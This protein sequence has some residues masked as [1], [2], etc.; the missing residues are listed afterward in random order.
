M[1][2]FW[3]EMPALRILLPFVAG[4]L[5]AIFTKDF[6]VVPNMPFIII[7][8][9]LVIIATHWLKNYRFRWLFG[10]TTAIILFC[11]GYQLSLQRT[12]NL[13]PQHYIHFKTDSSFVLLKVNTPLVEKARSY[14]TE[15]TVVGV[16]NNGENRIQPT[17]G[18][19]IAYFK[20]DT[21]SAAPNLPNY[22]DILLS[23]AVFQDIEEPQ[24]PNAFNYKQFLAYQNIYQQAYLRPTDWEF[25]HHKQ[26][27]WLFEK[28]YVLRAYLLNTI[29][30]YVAGKDQKAV[31]AALLLGYRHFLE[32]DMK[33]TYAHTGA[34]HVLAVSGLHVGIVMFVLQFMLQFLDKR[35]Y[36]K[37]L[38]VGIVIIGIWIFA[39]IAGLPPSVS[40]AALMFS[41]FALGGLTKPTYQCV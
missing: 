31:A 8:L 32:A 39:L 24:N 9:L 17:S 38:K 20:K 10:V 14:K 4:I 23:N 15:L 27:S 25:T 19:L 21:T 26:V 33:E 2:Y 11:L 35:K 6:F 40:R 29:N 16:F 12:H 18:K 30:Q 13:Q 34:M 1:Y 36:G 41:L 3:E 7:T 5:I 28:I 37:L 22:G